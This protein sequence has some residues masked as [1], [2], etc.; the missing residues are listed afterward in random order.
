MDFLIILLFIVF[1]SYF[2]FKGILRDGLKG[3]NLV[4]EKHQ[5]FM[6]AV[7]EPW[8]T[9]YYLGGITQLILVIL[10]IVISFKR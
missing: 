5:C 2:V 9:K 1:H 4:E 3:K 10:V 7:V 8:K 6:L